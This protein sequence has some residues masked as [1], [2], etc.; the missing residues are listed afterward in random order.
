MLFVLSK[1][2]QKNVKKF[3]IFYADL[4][5][6]IGSEQAGIRPVLIVQNDIGNKFS[7]TTIVLPLTKRIEKNKK[8]P[9]HI[10]IN[11][12]GNKIKK[13]TIMAEQIRAIDKKRLLFFVVKLPFEYREQVR[14]AINIATNF[15]NWR[16]KKC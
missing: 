8:L 5:Q 13:G 9:V 7:T 6:T 16:N 1:K 12:I 2:K 14:K 3:D 10:P 11:A 15:D 4:G